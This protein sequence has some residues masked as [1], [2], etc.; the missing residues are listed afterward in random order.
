MS[1]HT[2][3]IEHEV[4]YKNAEFNETV[5]YPTFVITYNFL[6]GAPARGPS[7]SHGGLPA[8]PD[9]IEFISATIKNNAGIAVTQDQID[10]WAQEWLESDRGFELAFE[11]AMEDIMGQ[12]D[13]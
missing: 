8:D 10:T 1:R 11:N 13:Y 3:I 4:E 9:E 2:I 12:C 7:Y 6:K 5:A